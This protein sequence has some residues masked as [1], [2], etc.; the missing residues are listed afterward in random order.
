MKNCM[1]CS[2]TKTVDNFEQV[3]KYRR[4]VCRA[5]RSAERTGIATSRSKVVDQV[6]HGTRSGYQDFRCRCV[7]CCS[8][9]K[10]YLVEHKYG[11]TKYDYER[12]VLAQDSKCPICGKRTD[13]FVVDHD[14]TCC[15]GKKSCGACVRGLVCSSCNWGLGQ[16]SDDP[17]IL[18]A[19]AAYL[20]QSRNVLEEV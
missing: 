5:C 15:S 20:L 1:R 10:W 6:P 4:N 11:I 12:M 13:D 7:S 17:E 8:A 14:H 9:N 18:L 3:G 16:F 2:L 19:A